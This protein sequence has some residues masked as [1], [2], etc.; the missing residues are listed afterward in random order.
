MLVMGLVSQAAQVNNTLAVDTKD[1]P[2]SP[3]CALSVSCR[4]SAR[5]FL[6]LSSWG[7]EQETHSRRVPAAEDCDSSVASARVTAVAALW[8]ERFKTLQFVVRLISFAQQRIGRGAFASPTHR[9]QSGWKLV[10]GENN[11]KENDGFEVT[12]L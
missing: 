7:T 10:F 1:F 11:W 5:S 6:L 2:V 4:R 3:T 9:W 12:Q 8:E